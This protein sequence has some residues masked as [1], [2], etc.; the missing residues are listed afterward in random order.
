MDDEDVIRLLVTRMLEQESFVVQTARDGAEAL[1]LYDQARAARTP[2]DLVILDLT[3][4]AGMGGLETLGELRKRDPRVRALVF[5]GYSTDPTV[6][7][8]REHGFRGVVPKPFRFAELVA[9]VRQAL[10]GG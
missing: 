5:S 10:A 8:F 9:A 4:P 2:F 1:T 3:V 6:T 7:D